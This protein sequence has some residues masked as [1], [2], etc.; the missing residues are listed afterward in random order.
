[1][2]Y[3]IISV[4]VPSALK[5]FRYMIALAQK[6]YFGLLVESTVESYIYISLIIA[7]LSPCTL[8]LIISGVCIIIYPDPLFI[9]ALHRYS[10][11]MNSSLTNVFFGY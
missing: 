11:S 1:M 2:P 3:P 7:D 10:L 5:L 9:T 6:I 8:F 4:Y